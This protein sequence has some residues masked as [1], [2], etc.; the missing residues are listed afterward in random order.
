MPAH[1]FWFGA[2]LRL[3]HFK[4]LRQVHGWLET[5][6]ASADGTAAPPTGQGASLGAQWS[7]AESFVYSR[8]DTSSHGSLRSP[9]GQA[10]A[11]MGTACPCRGSG[12][13]WWRGDVDTTSGKCK[14][15][16]ASSEPLIYSSIIMSRQFFLNSVHILIIC[17]SPSLFSM[18]IFHHMYSKPHLQVS[19]IILL[20]LIALLMSLFHSLCSHLSS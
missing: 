19:Y 18:G 1:S 11:R 10:T 7:F 8:N 6:V 15:V 14:R 5:S 12:R 3:S 2:L 9:R 13:H 17:L 4:R 16:E 20:F